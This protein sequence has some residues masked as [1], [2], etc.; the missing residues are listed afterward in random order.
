MRLSSGLLAALPLA[1]FLIVAVASTRSDAAPPQPTGERRTVVVE[2]FSSEGCSSCPSADAVLDRLAREQPVA[3]AEVIALELHVDYW[4]RLGWADPFSSA[5]FTARQGAYADALGKRDVYTPQA[6]VDGVTELLGS[7][8]RGV[9]EAVASAAREAKAKV[10]VTRSGDRVAIAI[11][12][13]AEATDSADVWLAITEDGLATAVPRGENAGATLTH[14]PVV[15]S[16]NRVA[17]IAAV[18]HG[19]V[20]VKDVEVAVNPGWRREALRAV[21]FVQRRRTL[22]IVG[23]GTTS[24]R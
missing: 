24:L 3:G 12:D 5:A 19:D 1:V 11:S 9:R 21:A 13:L 18:T 10:L 2:L 4:N 6:V 7:N 8:E 22:R 17:E 16:L 15:R 14:G 20:Q 23:A